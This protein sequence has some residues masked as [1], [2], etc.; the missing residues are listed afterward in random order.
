[1][2]GVKLQSELEQ[3]NKKYASMGF[4]FK[5]QTGVCV[6]SC[7]LAT[8]GGRAASVAGLKLEMLSFTTTVNCDTFTAIWVFCPASM[9]TLCAFL[10]V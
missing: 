2:T 5:L 3:N 10:E 6:E 4:F 9:I 7:L 8:V 1:L